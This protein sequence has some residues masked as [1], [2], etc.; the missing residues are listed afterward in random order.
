MS[1]C[2]FFSEIWPKKILQVA[3]ELENHDTT[4]ITAADLL[5]INL[6]N[7]R[8]II[9]EQLILRF[10]KWP[11]TIRKLKCKQNKTFFVISCFVNKVQMSRW[12]PYLSYLIRFYLRHCDLFVLLLRNVLPGFRCFSFRHFD[13]AELFLFSMT[14]TDNWW[15]KPWNLIWM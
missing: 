15:H 4:R 1:G 9:C 6:F 5:V 10:F 13:K 2:R 11:I 7:H 14:Q 3:A 8:W 12:N